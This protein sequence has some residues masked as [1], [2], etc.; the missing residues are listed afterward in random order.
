MQN[1]CRDASTRNITGATDTGGSTTACTASG[2]AY[3]A[4]THQITAT[5]TWSGDTISLIQYVTRWQ[6]RACAQ[7]SWDSVGAGPV[8]GCTTTLYDSATSLTT[9]ATLQIQ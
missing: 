3:D 2:G 8:T 9:G 6:N 1:V 5:V 7:A 4:S